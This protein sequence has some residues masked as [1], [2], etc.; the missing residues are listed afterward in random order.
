MLKRLSGVR[1]R[2]SAMAKPAISRIRKISG[3][4][5]ARKPIMSVLTGACASECGFLV[6]VSIDSFTFQQARSAFL[7][8]VEKLIL[9]LV[10]VPTSQGFV[11]ANPPCFSHLFGF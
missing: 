8:E 5:R 9:V 2:G 7:I 4:K 3:A 10:V 11:A 1:K 6:I